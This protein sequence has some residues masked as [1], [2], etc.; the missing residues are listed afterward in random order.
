MRSFPSGIWNLLTAIL[1]QHIES[2]HRMHTPFRLWVKKSRS[3]VRSSRKKTE[4]IS[5]SDFTELSRYATL[6]T[7]WGVGSAQWIIDVFRS[8]EN[9]IEALLTFKRWKNGR[10]SV[11]YVEIVRRW[12]LEYVEGKFKLMEMIRNVGVEDVLDGTRWVVEH[13]E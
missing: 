12:S 10:F 6:F 4:D 8:H 11:L 5:T 13:L 7:G 3:P 1:K 2:R 9:H